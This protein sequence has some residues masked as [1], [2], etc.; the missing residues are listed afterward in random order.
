VLTERTFDT[1]QP[2]A[3]RARGAKRY[4]SD[5]LDTYPTLAYATG[6]HLLSEGKRD[7]YTVEGSNADLRHYLARLQ[8]ASRCFSRCPKA[9]KRALFIF[10][11]AYNERQLRRIKNP[12]YKVHLIDCLPNLC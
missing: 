7:T 3:D 5:G 6:E 9:L 8:R 11:H 4:F 10:V 2:L 1:M 12:R